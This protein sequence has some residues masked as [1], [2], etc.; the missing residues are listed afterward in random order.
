MQLKATALALSLLAL[1]PAS[2]A[3]TMEKNGLPCVQEVCLGD[4]L[5]ELAK[6]NWTPAQ[7]TFKINNKVQLTG[8]RKLSDDD[9]RVLKASFPLSNEAAPFLHEKQFD[10]AGLKTL[11]RVTAAC[12]ANELF[13]TYGA[14]TGAPTKVGISLMPS[15][16]DANSQVWTVTSI[17]RDFPSAVSNEEKAT[18]TAL[19][20]R[21]YGKYGAGSLE[22]PSAKPGEGRFFLGGS[23][24]F[25]FGL[26]MVRPADEARR[27][28]AHP[29]CAAKPG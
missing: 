20:K 12:D 26:S 25:G 24:N 6:I 23:A 10:A 9:L 17:V 2:F 7:T 11:S 3:Q 28:K 16:A 5:T 19:L 13:G 22:L 29:M 18:I 8:A 15:A 1:Q 27:L 21:Q 4:S 14:G